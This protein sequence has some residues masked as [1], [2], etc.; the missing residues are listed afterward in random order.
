MNKKLVGVFLVLV[1]FLSLTLSAQAFVDV[2]GGVAFTGYNDVAIPSNTATRFSLADQTP[3][4]VVPA[5]RMRVGYTF[6]DRHTVS[7]LAAPL[8]AQGS[9]TIDTDV[10]FQNKLFLAGSKLTSSFRFDSYRLTYR[11]TFLKNDDI[12]LGIGLTGKIRS[13]EISLASDTGYVSRTDLGVVPLINFR[14]DWR[15]MDP[16]SLVL[17]GDA[18]ITPYGRAEDVQLALA[19]RYTDN[20]TFLLGYRILEGGSDG[21][22]KVYTFSMFHFITA[23]ITVKF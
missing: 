7:L 3:A 23:G 2:E 6:A 4:G 21:G 12:D 19:W 22:G 11:W 18:L 14:V 17:D 1:I 16:F 9:G 13:A 20:A 5:F 8:T 10:S 15:F